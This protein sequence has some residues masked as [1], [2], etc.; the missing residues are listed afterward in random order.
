MSKFEMQYN[1]VGVRF[2]YK[3]PPNNRVDH[4]E[5]TKQNSKNQILHVDKFWLKI[6][7]DTFP[8]I[9]II[10]L[11]NLIE[12]KTTLATS[13]NDGLNMRFL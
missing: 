10:T 8:E 4:Y 11:C 9:V 5:Y 2:L 7:T 3:H 12:I 1:V 13:N 6:T